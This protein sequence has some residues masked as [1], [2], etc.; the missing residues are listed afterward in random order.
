M[1]KFLEKEENITLLILFKTIDK[2]KSVLITI[3]I[4]K[5]FKYFKYL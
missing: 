3:N 5:V 4:F 2:R 1:L